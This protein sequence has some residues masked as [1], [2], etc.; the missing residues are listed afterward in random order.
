MTCPFE[1]VAER[2]TFNWE[3][4]AS[5]L[6]RG[7]TRLSMQ[8]LLRHDPQQA[9]MPHRSHTLRWTSPSGD[10]GA[11]IV[12]V[13]VVHVRRKRSRAYGLRVIHEE[14]LGASEDR[15]SHPRRFQQ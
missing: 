11:V 1:F 9:E 14:I 3:T 12:V 15:L 7:G 10:P 4:A 5:D 8:L 13:F 6:P 2:G